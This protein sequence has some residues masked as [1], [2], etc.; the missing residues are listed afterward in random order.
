MYLRTYVDMEGTHT[1]QEVKSE[2]D[3]VEA[4]EAADTEIF[5]KLSAHQL[6]GK[7]VDM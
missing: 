6:S 7:G 3:S 4:V 1:T 5:T 2:G